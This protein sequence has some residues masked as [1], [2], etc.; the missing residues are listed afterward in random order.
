[1]RNSLD[2]QIKLKFNP[3]EILL[4]LEQDVRNFSLN[5]ASLVVDW[6]SFLNRLYYKNVQPKNILIVPKSYQFK[7]IQLEAPLHVDKISFRYLHI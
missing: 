3:Y 7:I 4:D 1:M 5:Q 6:E 2:E